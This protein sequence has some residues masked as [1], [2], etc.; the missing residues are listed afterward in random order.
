MNRNQELK[1]FKLWR[2]VCAVKGWK[3]GDNA[4]RHAVHES[5]FGYDLSHKEMDNRHVDKI[6]NAFRLMADDTNLDA[7]LFFEDLDREERK[8]LIWR[9][10]RL[11]D[12]PYIKSIAADV[13]KTSYWEA[14]NV[15]QLTWMRNTLCSR[16]AAQ[17]RRAAAG[18][19]HAVEVEEAHATAA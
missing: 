18:E 6:F 5:V 1:Y 16:T 15:E 3:S 17:K 13:F 14:L 7:A 11:A 8:R 12:E 2:Q 9:I 10:K 19:A 4:R